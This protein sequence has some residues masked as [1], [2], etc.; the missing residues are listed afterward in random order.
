MLTPDEFNNAPTTH[1]EKP[2]LVSRSKRA[3]SGPGD[4]D[5][6]EGDNG[7]K[8][9]S[10]LAA[11]AAKKPR[12]HSTVPVSHTVKLHP[13]VQ[14]IKLSTIAREFN[15][16][17]NEGLQSLTFQEFCTMFGFVHSGLLSLSKKTP[18]DLLVIESYIEKA[19]KAAE[20]QCE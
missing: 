11:N 18:D 7:A 4:E 14:G 5:G 16:L 12:L 10:S 19:S 3:R 17:E 9:R 1:P 15:F 8:S 13:D 6:F 20:E 2:N